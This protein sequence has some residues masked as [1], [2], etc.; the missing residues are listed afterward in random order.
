MR[1]HHGR[2]CDF[3]YRYVRSHETAEDIVQDIFVRILKSGAFDFDD[4]LAYLYR[5]AQRRREPPPP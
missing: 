3:V 5:A 2:L 1:A 4:P